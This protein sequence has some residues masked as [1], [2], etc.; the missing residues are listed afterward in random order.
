MSNL[1][2]G[3][4][5]FVALE[6]VIFKLI[7][8]AIFHFRSYKLK[9]DGDSILRPG[10]EDIIDDTRKMGNGPFELLIGREFKL[11]IW[12]EMVKTMKL[13]EVARFVCPFKV[14]GVPSPS[15]SVGKGQHSIIRR[16][17]WLSNYDL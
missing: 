14:C 16:C 13:T 1:S 4:V 15:P 11:D 12:D 5:K 7:F 10:P 2:F 9:L 8:Q 6:L 3:S 17:Q